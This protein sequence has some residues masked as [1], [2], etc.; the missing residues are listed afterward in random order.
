M[1]ENIGE[2]AFLELTKTGAELLGRLLSASLKTALEQ[3]IKNKEMLKGGQNNIK[4]LLN[5]SVELKSTNISGKENYIDIV[6]SAKKE[7]LPISVV[8]YGEDF[9]VIYRVEDEKRITA[10]LSEKVKNK[11]TENEK[12]LDVPTNQKDNN[13]KNILTI[14]LDNLNDPLELARVS[15]TLTEQ[16]TKN[17]ESLELSL[18]KS[19]NKEVEKK[20]SIFQNIAKNI[21]QAVVPKNVLNVMEQLTEQIEQ[22][23]THEPV[24]E[25][26][27]DFETL[28]KQEQ[29]K[30][31]ELSERCDTL[32]SRLNE[33]LDNY[34]KTKD[35]TKDNSKDKENVKDNTNNK[36]NNNK[37]Q[38]TQ[39]KA[40]NNKTDN[41]EVEKQ[42]E[43]NQEHTQEEKSVYGNKDRSNNKGIQNAINEGKKQ[44]SSQKQNNQTKQQTKAKGR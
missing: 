35:N 23:Q 21:T 44:V 6:Q 14:D 37:Q 2:E 28:F 1:S 20:P 8:N 17:K 22:E 4:K 11:I 13:N 33:V 32:E 19:K 30:N 24:T 29:A 40:Q 31:I 12:S 16:L 26:T 5:N 38:N 27:Q 39:T 25:Q 18:N 34:D 43:N 41:T 42:T 3:A 9:K 10:L 15:Q 7:G 36:N